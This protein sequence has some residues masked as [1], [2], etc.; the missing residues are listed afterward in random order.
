MGTARRCYDPRSTV[1]L[2]P[3]SR[4]ESSLIHAESGLVHG[5]SLKTGVVHGGGV[6]PGP[7]SALGYLPAA[8]PRAQQEPKVAR[9]E[10]VTTAVAIEVSLPAGS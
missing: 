2:G 7:C 6:Y 9:R 1:T 8:E 3:L 5:T 4:W 10:G